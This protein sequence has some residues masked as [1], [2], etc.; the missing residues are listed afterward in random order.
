M[1]AA[2]DCVRHAV[3][4]GSGETNVAVYETNWWN[5]RSFPNPPS[6]S[7]STSRR[8]RLVFLLTICQRKPAGHGRNPLLFVPARRRWTTLP[9]GATCRRQNE[10]PFE[11]RG[12]SGRQNAV[13]RPLR[14][15][16]PAPVIPPLFWPA[17]PAIA[18]FFPCSTAWPCRAAV[19]G[20]PG[21]WRHQR[22]RFGGAGGFR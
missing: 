8:K 9:A 22:F 21:V 20:E 11:Q 12:R 7:A 13:C 10:Q 19:S 18:P 14:Q 16:L 3:L 4:I 17:A 6:P 5:W 2:S 15:L 1:E